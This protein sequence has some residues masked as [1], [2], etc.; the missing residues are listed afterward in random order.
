M[1]LS[2]EPLALFAQAVRRGTGPGIIGWN[3][4]YR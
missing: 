2:L 4:E 3:E 1:S